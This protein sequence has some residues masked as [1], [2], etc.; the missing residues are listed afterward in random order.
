MKRTLLA[1]IVF[2]AI[3]PGAAAAQSPELA[4][5]KAY[6]GDN[7]RKELKKFCKGVPGGDNRLIACLYSHEKALSPKCGTAVMASLDRLNKSITALANAQR[8]CEA[9]AKRLCNGMLAGDGN[10]IGCL[11]KA[12]NS[13]SPACNATLDEA[14]MRP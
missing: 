12:R 6:V 3:F 8:V 11:A 1:A 7:C 4:Q 5:W 9:D 13:V 14:L 10:L 2:G